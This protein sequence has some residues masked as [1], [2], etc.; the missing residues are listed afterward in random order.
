MYASMVL[1]V[2]AGTLQTVLLFEC[3]FRRVLLLP[4]P[5]HRPS[6]QRF[7]DFSVVTT[8]VAALL[9]ALTIPFQLLAALIATANRYVVLVVVGFTLYAVLA[10]SAQSSVYV[11]AVMVRFYNLGVAPIAGTLRYALVIGDFVYRAFI[12]LWNGVVFF[13]SQLLTALWCPFPSIARVRF[14]KSCKHWH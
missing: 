11:F 4:F 8:A 10:V 9:Q 1:L 5:A 6:I 7:A 2:L 14:L 12:P 13:I 3:L